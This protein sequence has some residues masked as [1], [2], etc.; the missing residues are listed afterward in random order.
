ME[1]ASGLLSAF[2]GISRSLS[3]SLAGWLIA[4]AISVCEVQGQRAF[5]ADYFLDA[6]VMDQTLFAIL[7]QRDTQNATNIVA[8]K[9][10]AKIELKPI[11]VP[12]G[13]TWMFL[14]SN[15]PDR[16]ILAVAACHDEV[17]CEL[18]DKLIWELWSINPDSK[19]VSLLYTAP[20]GMMIGSPFVS[21]AKDILVPLSAFK[22]NLGLTSMISASTVVV[23]DAEEPTAEW[24]DDLELMQADGRTF[25]YS[26]GASIYVE[27]IIAYEK[28]HVISVLGNLESEIDPGYRPEAGRSPKQ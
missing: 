14:E 8:G 5:A 16:S 19:G 23:I 2:S 11:D 27:S 20:E 13:R 6:S 7:A 17:V 12:E 26:R 9:I 1:E 28:G 25:V 24:P 18:D 3:Y 4:L 15:Y 22:G 10:Q 21:E